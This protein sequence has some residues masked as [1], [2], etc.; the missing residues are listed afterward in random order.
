MKRN[1]AILLLAT[2]TLAGWL[3]SCKSNNPEVKNNSPA[4]L[5]IA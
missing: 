2:L 1:P 5:L 3:M 4:V